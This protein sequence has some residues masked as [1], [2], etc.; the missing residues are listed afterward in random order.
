MIHGDGAGL[1]L[2]GLARRDSPRGLPGDAAISD[3]SGH[4]DTITYTLTRD[5]SLLT[6]TRKV[7]LG[8]KSPRKR[9]TNE[10]DLVFHGEKL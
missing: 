2:W 10:I 3:K 4:G 9:E 1:I 8:E 5:D 7:P 6:A